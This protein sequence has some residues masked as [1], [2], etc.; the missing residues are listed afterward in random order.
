MGGARVSMCARERTGARVRLCGRA[1]GPR[2]G[3][4][5]AYKVDQGPSPAHLCGLLQ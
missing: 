3:L 5:A 1:R 2:V 4:E